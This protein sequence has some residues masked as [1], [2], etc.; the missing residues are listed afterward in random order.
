MQD[1]TIYNCVLDKSG[2]SIHLSDIGLGGQEERVRSMVTHPRGMTVFAGPSGSGKTTTLFAALG[3]ISEGE[4]NFITFEDLT[5]LP[6]PGIS[7][8]QIKLP[9]GQA[10]EAG[11]KSILARSPDIALVITETYDTDMAGIE[12][13]RDAKVVRI[14]LQAALAGRIVLAQME[15]SDATD[16]LMQLA[17]IAGDPSLVARA[18]AGILAQ[19]LLRRICAACKTAV[20]PSESTLKAL[21]MDGRKVT[22]YKGEGCQAC[23]GSGFKGRIAIHEMLVM[24]EE[25]RQLLATNVSADKIRHSARQ[26][27]MLTL[28]EDG[29]RKALTGHTTVEEVLRFT[30]T[31]EG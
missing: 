26:S 12:L 25:I 20:E 6:L 21:G 22:F 1:K 10:F 19:C 30:A 8:T 18:T 7:Q 16:A 4:F 31:V 23:S 27:G 28:H 29:L 11:L 24:D 3:E 15:A 14:A 9:D 17:V 2:L 5:K 13:I